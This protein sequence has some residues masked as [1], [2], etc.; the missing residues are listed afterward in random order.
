MWINYV[1]Y[2]KQLRAGEQWD[3]NSCTPFRGWAHSLIQEKAALPWRYR[4][5]QRNPNT[6]DNS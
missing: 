2:R 6:A 5:D 4:T 1:G 3:G